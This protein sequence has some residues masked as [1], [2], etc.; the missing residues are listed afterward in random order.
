MRRA[1]QQ[2]VMPA[3]G[4]GCRRD[5]PPSIA[6]AT[7]CRRR[8]ST[9]NPELR[10]RNSSEGI[11]EVLAHALHRVILRQRRCE[12][13][14]HAVRHEHER[15]EHRP[16]GGRRS[17]RTPW[18]SKC[19]ARCCF[20]RRA[21]CGHALR[22]AVRSSWCAPP[23]GSPTACRRRCRPALH[24]GGCSLATRRAKRRSCSAKPGA[25]EPP[26][27]ISWPCGE[28]VADPL[29]QFAMARQPEYRAKRPMST[30]DVRRDEERV[31]QL[32]RNTG[33]PAFEGRRK[34]AAV[35]EVPAAARRPATRS[36][37]CRDARTT[38]TRSRRRRRRASHQWF[39][40]AMPPRRWPSPNISI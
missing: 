10:P 34:L 19:D 15:R 32:Q 16:S 3:G 6:R 17:S 30:V 33:S 12:R 14:I 35:H 40:V 25:P 22:F 24:A 20:L 26:V 5:R 37:P 29:P 8:T 4:C 13:R 23:S 1:E 2:Q 7:S 11:C 36:R 18:V 9:N 21:L 27:I 39:L 38:P 31:F 28:V